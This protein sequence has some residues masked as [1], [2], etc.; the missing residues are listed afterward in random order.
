MRVPTCMRN[1]VVGVRDERTKSA[2]QTIKER[3]GPFTPLACRTSERVGD[4]VSPRSFTIGGTVLCKASANSPV[5][6]KECR[7]LV[8]RRDSFSS[9]KRKTA[10]T[11]NQAPY[12]LFPHFEA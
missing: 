9:H 12:E 3:V 8:P 11:G 10:S 6:Q 5:S 1:V 7:S 2:V 4:M